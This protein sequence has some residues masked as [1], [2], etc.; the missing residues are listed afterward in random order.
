MNKTSLTVLIGAVSIIGA[1]LFFVFS[2][3][4]KNI[5]ISKQNVSVTE[6]EENVGYFASFAIYTNGTFRIFTD[7]RYHNLSEDVF[8]ELPNSN[9]VHVKKSNITWGDF[10][11]TL[12]MSLTQDCL[13]TGTKQTFC[14]NETYSLQFFI[15]GSRNQSALSE[16]IQ[17]NDKLLI[18]YEKED[19]ILIPSQIQ[20][21][22]QP[23]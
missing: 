15:N 8:I 5:N 20:S 14:T 22:P 6:N 1:I 18:T 16:I 21:I 9:T 17:P 2:N 4:S 23:N 19:S 3:S 7:S 10:F 13:T 11:K 12:P